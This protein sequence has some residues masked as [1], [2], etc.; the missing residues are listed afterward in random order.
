[1]TGWLK[2][3]AK[4]PLCLDDVEA[5]IEETDSLVVVQQP[6]VNALVAWLEARSAENGFGDDFEWT[7]RHPRERGVKP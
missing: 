3:R 7:L 6:H 2:K 5:L 4:E 1:M